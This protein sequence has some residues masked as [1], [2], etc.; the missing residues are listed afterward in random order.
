M[1]ELLNLLL[2]TLA[3]LFRNRHDLVFENLLLGHQLWPSVELDR[4]LP[5]LQH[6]ERVLDANRATGESGELAPPHPD[7]LLPIRASR[8]PRL[9]ANR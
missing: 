4:L 2:P 1:L 7:R 5:P 3:S 6:L 9:H 8:N